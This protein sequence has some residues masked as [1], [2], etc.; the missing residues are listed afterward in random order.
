MRHQLIVTWSLL[1]ACPT[2]THD[3][4]LLWNISWLTTPVSW[5][6][7]DHSNVPEPMNIELFLVISWL[8][9]PAHGALVGHQLIVTCSMQ[10]LI[11][12]SCNLVTWLGSAASMHGSRDWGQLPPLVTCLGSAA[13][14]DHVT[15]V[16]CPLA[17]IA[18]GWSSFLCTSSVFK[19]MLWLASKF[20]TILYYFILTMINVM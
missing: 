9:N 13:S 14:R 19:K 17:T 3:M 11:C 15:G 6:S 18:Q 1:P 10:L 16:S 20:W 2:C 12:F 5:L 8:T 7:R 4:E